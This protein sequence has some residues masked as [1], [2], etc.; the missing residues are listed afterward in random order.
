MRWTF[1][2]SC[3]GERKKI[4]KISARALQLSDDVLRNQVAADYGWGGGGGG[5]CKTQTMNFG[6]INVDSTISCPTFIFLGQSFSAVKSCHPSCSKGLFWIIKCNPF[7][8]CFYWPLAYQ[9]ALLPDRP[10]SFGLNST[11][12]EPDIEPENFHHSSL[13]WQ[14]FRGHSIESNVN[15]PKASSAFTGE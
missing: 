8:W 10:L 5:P 12:S 6:H 15:C 3:F 1:R 14:L 4:T 11:V 7:D 13:I 2:A 9:R